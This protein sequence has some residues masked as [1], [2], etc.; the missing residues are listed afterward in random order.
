MRP[1]F[2][3]GGRNVFEMSNRETP[4]AAVYVRHRN[5]PI[6]PSQTVFQNASLRPHLY[7]HGT[8]KRKKKKIGQNI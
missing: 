8:R 1:F 4:D 6:F 2:E 3:G 5:D 7:R